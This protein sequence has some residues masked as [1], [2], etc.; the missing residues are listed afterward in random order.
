MKF[1][2]HF[3]NLLGTVYRQ[4]DLVFSGDSSR[5]SA[6]VGNKISMYDLRRHRAETLPVEGR[7]NFTRLALSPSGL[8]LIAADEEGQISVISL[9]SRQVDLA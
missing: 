6:C 1:H 4:G 3:S 2:Y 5:V 7:T 9:V 8:L